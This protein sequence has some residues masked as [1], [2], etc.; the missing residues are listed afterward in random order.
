MREINQFIIHC[1]ATPPSMDIGFEDIH[2]WHLDRGW[3]GC[4]YHYIIR[5]DGTIEEGRPVEFAGA[6][7]R[8]HNK[9]SVG[10][11]YVGGVDENLDPADTRTILQKAALQDLIESL[12]MV[13]GECETLGHCDLHG[14]TKACPSFDVKEWIK[15]WKR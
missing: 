7:A 9:N 6:H 12:T 2:Q 3:S 4:G 1:S 10:I 15:T 5:R 8:G 13:F 11:C 14:V